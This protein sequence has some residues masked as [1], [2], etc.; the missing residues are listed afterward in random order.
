MKGQGKGPR[1]LGSADSASW[2]E[3]AQPG[4]R[5]GYGETVRG[6]RPDEGDMRRQARRHATLPV[7]QRK[8]G[9]G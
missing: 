6:S 1:L 4:E 2:E 9:R 5:M 8:D 7:K 3:D